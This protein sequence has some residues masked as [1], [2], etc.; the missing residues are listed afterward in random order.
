[1]NAQAQDSQSKLQNFVPYGQDGLN[2]FE[3]LKQDTTSYQGFAIKMGGAFTQQLQSLSHSTESTDPDVSLA[4]IGTGLNLATANLYLD[5]QMADGI[6]LHLTTYLSSRHHSEAWVK[7]G[8]L[9][10]DKMEMLNS[11][12]INNIFNY[13]TVKAGHMEINYGDAHFRR[14]DNAH[15]IQNPFV[16]NYI[17][18]SFTTE[19]AAEVYVNSGD[20]LGMIAYSGGQLHPSVANPD[21]RSASV[22]GKLGY[23][24]TFSPALRFRLT[25]SFYTNDHATQLYHG[26]R[27][28][29]RFYNVLD[30]GAWSGRFSPSLSGGF[31]SFM[32]NPFVK[33]NGLELFGLIENAKVKEGD[34]SWNQF[35]VD[36]VYRFGTNDDLY[37]G[38]RYNTVQGDDAGAD[39]TVNRVSFSGGWYMTNNILVKLEYL[40]QEYKDYP[41]ASLYHGASFDGLMI[42]GSI[43]F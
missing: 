16:G 35:A 20:F 30:G 8:Y 29:S 32:V 19:V 42:E 3:G 27:A 5:A 13:V 1:M 18:D 31:T 11:D 43:A 10:V 23:D 6:R 15:S 33:F 2:A 17:M 26:D 37:V 39:V 22:Y 38:A 40:N 4:D 28:G 34:G 9:Q 36:G 24:K 12:V 41:S 7:G 14:T 21:D 25:G